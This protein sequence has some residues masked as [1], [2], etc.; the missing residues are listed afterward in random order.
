[1]SN[2]RQIHGDGVK[3]Q[4]WLVHSPPMS[5]VR[6][7]ARTSAGRLKVILVSV[8]VPRSPEGEMQKPFNSIEY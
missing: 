5:L 1:M 7:R 6:K 2:E 4:V 8:D 3:L